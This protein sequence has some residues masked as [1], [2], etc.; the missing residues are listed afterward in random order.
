VGALYG[1]TPEDKKTTEMV[2]SMRGP[3]F[4]WWFRWS[5]RHPEASWGK[6]SWTL[7]WYFKPEY[8]DVLPIPDDEDWLDLNLDDGGISMNNMGVS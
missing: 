2:K 4:S 6:F 7:F 1:Q 3:A 5:L 8:Q